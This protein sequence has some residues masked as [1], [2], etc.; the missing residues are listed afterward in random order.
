MYLMA[1]HPAWLPRDEQMRWNLS[2]RPSAS[3]RSSMSS[4]ALLSDRRGSGSLSPYPARSNATRYTPSSSSNS[5]TPRVGSSICFR[6]H[7]RHGF[8]A[9]DR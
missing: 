4:A 5:C 6:R 1:A 7:V 8:H 3:A 2:P 9:G